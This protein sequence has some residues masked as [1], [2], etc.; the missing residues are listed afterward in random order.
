MLGEYG[1]RPVSFGQGVQAGGQPNYLGLASNAAP[2]MSQYNMPGLFAG[3]SPTASAAGYQAAVASPYGTLGQFGNLASRYGQL[4][5][6]GGNLVSQL[7]GAIARMRLSGDTSR[8]AA[9][10]GGI[11]GTGLGIVGAA[12]VPT[13][14]GPAGASAGW[15]LGCAAGQQVGRA[16]Y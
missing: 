5:Q 14:G 16:T 2:G 11:W 13:L 1:L 9:Q 3:G 4:V 8:A 10:S 7:T 15:T 6:G 12:A